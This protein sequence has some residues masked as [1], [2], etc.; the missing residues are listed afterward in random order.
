MKSFLLTELMLKAVAGLMAASMLLLSPASYAN[1]NKNIV[2][3]VDENETQLARRMAERE[4][5]NPNVFYRISLG[6]RL[7]DLDWS[8]AIQNVNVASQVEWDDLK[9]YQAKFEAKINLKHDWFVNGYYAAGDIVSGNASDA[10]YAGR[11]K[12]NLISYMESDASGSVN[13]VSISVGKRL[14]ISISKVSFEFFPQLGFSFHQQR[15][16]MSDG[17]QKVPFRISLPQLDNSYD[18]EWSGFW[19]GFDASSEFRPGVV[20]NYSFQYHFVDYSAEANWNLRRDLQHPVSFEHDANGDGLIFS[21][22]VDYSVSRN[23]LLGMQIEYQDWETSKGQ[24]KTFFST[25][26]TERYT[27]NPVQ[28]KSTIYSINLS[29]QF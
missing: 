8:I 16:N 23:L 19:F 13:D 4:K 7:D 14:N 28:W 17:L 25:G 29:Y 24:D 22:G 18:A 20:L 3:E 15:L 2:D 11:N 10:D 12:T 21:F 6:Y 5:T 26:S 9:I 1:D 27:L